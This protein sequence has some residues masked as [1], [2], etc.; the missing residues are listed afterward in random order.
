MWCEEPTHWKS[1]WC[2]EKTEGMKIRGWQRMRWLDGITNSK[3]MSLSKLWEVLKDRKAWCAASMSV[4][5]QR[6]GLSDWTTAAS[7]LVYPDLQLTPSLPSLQFMRW[8]LWR[9]P[10][11]FPLENNPLSLSPVTC[12]VAALCLRSHMMSIKAWDFLRSYFWDGQWLS[13]DQWD[14]LWDPRGGENCHVFWLYLNPRIGR[15]SDK[16][17]TLRQNWLVKYKS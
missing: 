10:L 9:L 2:W 13:Q 16:T 4:A 8:N 11:D 6:V 14:F 7:L 17:D 5:S 12:S 15:H 3:D 1:P